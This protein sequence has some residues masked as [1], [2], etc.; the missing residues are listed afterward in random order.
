MGGAWILLDA[1]AHHMWTCEKCREEAEESFD[2]CRNCG[3]PRG[4]VLLPDGIAEEAPKEPEAG[5]VATPGTLSPA[6]NAGRSALGRLKWSLSVLVLIALLFAGLYG[7]NPGDVFTPRVSGKLTNLGDFLARQHKEKGP[8]KLRFIPVDKDG[9]S[10]LRDKN[11][12]TVTVKDDLTFNVRLRPGIWTLA[13]VIDL[14][15]P[16]GEIFLPLGHGIEVSSSLFQDFGT[17][18]LQAQ[19]PKDGKDR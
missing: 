11:G 9:T 3:S 12:E 15:P 2:V 14:G 17:I 6:A 7:L 10:I 8:L 16:T 5:T 13:V 19:P 1:E 4:G 18:D